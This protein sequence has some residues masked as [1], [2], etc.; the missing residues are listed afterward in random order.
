V[1]RRWWL[2]IGVPLVFAVLIVGALLVTDHEVNV[3]FVAA[4]LAVG[5]LLLWTAMDLAPTVPYTS[6]EVTAKYT[7]RQPGRDPRLER[8][9][10]RLTSGVDRE[11]VAQYVHD[12]LS[13]VVDDRLRRNHGIDRAADPS[14]AEQVLGSAL[15]TYL[16]TKPH[17]RRTGQAQDLAALLN[18]IEEL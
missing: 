13:E 15:T 1:R 6:W 16:Y 5:C 18:R 10:E 12:A 4:A 7:P 14:A 11:A 17:L 8:F 2:R 3:G 9:T